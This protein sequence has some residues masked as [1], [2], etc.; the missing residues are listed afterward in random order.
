MVISKPHSMVE[1]FARVRSALG[2]ASRENE[3][4]GRAALERIEEQLE[5]LG[6]IGRL[7][8]RSQGFE[9]NPPHPDDPSPYARLYAHLDVED[10]RADLRLLE[11][12]EI[13]P[14]GES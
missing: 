11:L 5:A 1:D 10:A 14:V 3:A 12:Y 6:E 8:C 4:R 7:I 13:S 9:E 2:A